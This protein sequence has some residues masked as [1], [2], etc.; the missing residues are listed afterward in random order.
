M[1]NITSLPPREEHIDRFLTEEVGFAREMLGSN[2]DRHDVVTEPLLECYEP[3]E[4]PDGHIQLGRSGVDDFE[5]TFQIE[6]LNPSL[7]LV[8]FKTIENCLIDKRKHSPEFHERLGDLAVQFL[9]TNTKRKTVTEARHEAENG[10]IGYVAA[11]CAQARC[12]VL[13][14]APGTYRQSLPARIMTKASTRPRHDV[15]AYSD[16]R[17]KVIPHFRLSLPAVDHKIASIIKDAR[18]A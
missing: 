2:P 1:G 14:D 4:Y 16:E 3:F 15:A 10:L 18:T 6:G 8:V 7:L 12:A 9:F 5:Q 13:L 11:R 17:K